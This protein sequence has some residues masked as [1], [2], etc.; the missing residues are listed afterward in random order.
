MPFSYYSPL[1]AQKSRTINDALFMMGNNGSGEV[2]AGTVGTNITSPTL[3][4]ADYGTALSVGYFYTLAI[5]TDGTLYAWG[6]GSLGC[7]GTGNTTNRSSPVQVGALSGWTHVAASTNN[8]N[9]DVYSSLGIRDGALYSWGYNLVGQ[10][11]LGNTTSVSSPNQVGADTDW[12]AIAI[13][14][15]SSYGIKGDLAYGSLYSWG[16]NTSGQLGLNDTTDRSS[17]VLVSAISGVGAT[18]WGWIGVTAGNNFAV[19]VGTYDYFDGAQTVLA[20]DIYA[21]GDNFTGQLGVNDTTARSTPTAVTGLFTVYDDPVY[22]A[23]GLNHC[24]ALLSNDLYAWG[25]NGYGQLG[26]GTTVSKSSAVFIGSGYLY[27]A[28]GLYSSMAIK[29]DGTLWAWGQNDN[30]QLGDLSFTTR[31]SPVQIGTIASF[32]FIK[33][34]AVGLHSGFVKNET[35]I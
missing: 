14:G 17:P 6:D 24:L 9:F 32:G 1:R 18:S 13:N 31:S 29:T 4:G 10:L 25:G 28:A 11:G 5:R 8:N 19:A 23:A 21:W 33:P 3:V 22:V 12:Y 2:G 15:I 7:L 27:I 16:N 35:Q 34:I 20:Q 26:D 30:G